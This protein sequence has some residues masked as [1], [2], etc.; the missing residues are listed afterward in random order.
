MKIALPQDDQNRFSAHY[1]AATRIGCFQIDPA[2]RAA[3]AQETLLPLTPSPCA[4]PDWL[5]AE[6]VTTLLVGGMGPGARE[7]CTALGIEV[8]PG[9]PASD[10]AP[11]LV[12]AY[13]DG[14]LTLSEHACRHGDAAHDHDHGNEHA[15]P[16]AP[17]LSG[18]GHCH[19]SH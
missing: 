9:V 5:R 12:A 19:C 4:W 1:G 8:V 3:R 17:A 14:T 10:A 2:T 11:A 7:R 13:L 16:H 18:H 6:G 15:H